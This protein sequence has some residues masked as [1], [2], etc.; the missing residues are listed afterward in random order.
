MTNL[1][2]RTSTSEKYQA[3]LIT[4]L[5]WLAI[6]PCM[7]CADEGKKILMINSN[8]SVEKYRM[9]GK[10][11]GKAVPYP[12][13]DVSLDKGSWEEQSVRSLPEPDLVYCIGTKAYAVASK[14]MKEK[15]IVFSSILNWLRLPMTPKTHGISNE[16]HT[17]MQIT[18]F[19]YIFP[20]VGK[21]GVLY[22]KQF[23][24]KWFENAR[25]D[26]E[27]MGVKLIGRAI[28]ENRQVIPALDELLSHTD[29]FWLIS[30]PMIMSEKK[31][32]V[33]NSEEL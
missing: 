24:R 7:V 1:S 15:N 13:S 21:I 17:E 26:A 18:M 16:L 30:D 10:A 4:C 28:S 5:L 29:A 3:K 32:S 8:A 11:F 20:D 19:R 23:N 33:Q 14:Y 22:S 31:N 6:F 2:T 12:V 9:V 25:A 27:N